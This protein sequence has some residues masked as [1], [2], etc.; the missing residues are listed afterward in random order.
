MSHFSVMVIG[1]DVEKQLAPYHEFECTGTVNEYVQ[2]ID[3]LPDLLESF[4][5]NTRTML[6][7]PEG[8]LVSAYDE[9]FYREQ[10]EEEKKGKSHLDASSKIRFV[11]E[12]WTE[13]EVVVNEFMSLIDLIRYETGD[14]FPILQEGED[15]D[16]HDR[17]KWGWARVNAAGEVIEYTYRTNPNTQWDWYQIGGRWSGFLKLKQDAAGSLGHRG[18]MGSCA[19][20]GEGRA[21]VA[22]KGAIDFEGMRDEAG[23]KAAANWDKAAEAKISAGFAAD[24]TWDSWEVVRERHPGNI[25]AAREEYHAQG[26][27][28]AVDKALNLWDGAD[29]YLTPRDE[30]IQQARDS[31]LVLFAMVKDSKWF[32]K[33]EMGWFGMSTDSMTQAEWNRKVNEL[34]D[35][36]PDDTLITIVDCHI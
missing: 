8:E 30:F 29:D 9:R 2:T 26:A 7:G 25:E 12:G 3:Q 21:D 10:T 16:L 22:L 18:L 1:Q 11:P 4:N 36:L 17:C 35:E 28:K 15:P 32:A 34:L 27:M 20:D 14:D 31:A 24:A 23:A 5:K 19:N 6:R 33:G 13:Q